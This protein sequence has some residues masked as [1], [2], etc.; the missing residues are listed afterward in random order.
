M[1]SSCQEGFLDATYNNIYS[2]DN[3][4]HDV[5]KGSMRGGAFS[6]DVAKAFPSIHHSYARRFFSAVDAPNWIVILFFNIFC[7]IWHHLM[8]GD[9]IMR[10]ALL[11]RGIT[12]GNP[13]S[14]YFFIILYEPLILLIQFQLLENEFCHAYADDVIIILIN[15]WRLIKIIPVFM[16]F[17]RASGCHLNLQKSQWL[18]CK[19]PNRRERTWYNQL[20]I[21]HFDAASQLQLLPRII[22]LGVMLGIG[23]LPEERLERPFEAGTRWPSP[24]LYA[25]SLPIRL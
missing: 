24:S 18:Y 4:I 9:V 8:V 6:S 12:Q 23:V 21:Q 14:A 11:E 15:I 13:L 1:T 22:Y 25:F 17:A 10:G 20:D 3:E 2:A 5:N 19:E 16:L 7:G